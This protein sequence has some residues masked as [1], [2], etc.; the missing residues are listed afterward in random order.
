MTIDFKTK[1]QSN[2]AQERCF[3]RLSP[4]ERIYSFLELIEKI[5][6]F[7]VTD[8]GDKKNNFLIELRT[9]SS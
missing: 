6:V 3:L 4:I 8:L 7:P 2:L 1:E 5:K 9:S